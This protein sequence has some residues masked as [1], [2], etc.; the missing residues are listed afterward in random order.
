[1]KSSIR[2]KIIFSELDFVFGLFEVN[3]EINV[4]TK[5]RVPEEAKVSRRKEVRNHLRGKGHRSRSETV[6][7][8]PDSRGRCLCLIGPKNH[9]WEGEKLDLTVRQQVELI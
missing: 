5:T 1:M 2:K 3:R 9:R 4:P 8:L 7:A 6:P